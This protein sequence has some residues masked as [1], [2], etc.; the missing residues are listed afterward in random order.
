MKLAALVHCRSR[1]QSHEE[2]YRGFAAM[3]R[4]EPRGAGS[5]RCGRWLGG[6]VVSVASAGAGRV[7]APCHTCSCRTPTASSSRSGPWRSGTWADQP[8]RRSSLAVQARYHRRTDPAVTRASCDLADLLAAGE[9]LRSRTCPRRRVSPGVYP[10]PCAYLLPG[11]TPAASRRHDPELYAFNL[12]N[13]SYRFE[14]STA[15]MLQY[16]PAGGKSIPKLPQRKGR[17]R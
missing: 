10:R 2:H 15:T 5:C 9:P 14:N 3:R 16:I 13:E 12:V 17:R 8:R 7:R 11:H 4:R 6:V 1:M